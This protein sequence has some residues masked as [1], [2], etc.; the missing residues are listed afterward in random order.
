MI[1][2]HFDVSVEFDIEYHPKSDCMSWGWVAKH[3]TGGWSIEESYLT[4]LG[5]L[6]NKEACQRATGVA[7]TEKRPVKVATSIVFDLEYDGLRWSLT[8][9][10]E[11]YH[12]LYPDVVLGRVLQFIPE[13]W[14]FVESAYE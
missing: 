4:L 12:N 13:V 7:R 5:P 10:G 9:E 11:T 1:K 2:R 3:P 14:K 6:A 8:H